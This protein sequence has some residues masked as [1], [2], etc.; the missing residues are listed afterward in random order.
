MKK[1]KKTSLVLVPKQKPKL[2]IEVLGGKAY[3]L[4]QMAAIKGIQVPPFFVVTADLYRQLL[5]PKKA[6]KIKSQIKSLKAASLPQIEK[7]ALNIRAFFKSSK[8]DD[9]TTQ[10]IL[11]AFKKLGNHTPVAVRSSATCEDLP[12]A[13]FAGQQDTYLNVRGEKELLQAVKNCL[14]SLF[15]VRAIVYRNEQKINHQKAALSVVVQK[16]INSHVSGVCFSVE[17]TT[18]FPEVIRIDA[19]YGLGEAIVQGLVTPDAFMVT[20]S[21]FILNKELGQKETQ[22]IYAKKG[23]KTLSVKPILSTKW[24]M[25]D[26]KVLKL[27]KKVKIL[28]N[29]YQHFVDVEFAI[30]T[31]GQIF[32]VQVR[33]ETKWQLLKNK[34]PHL[35][36]ISK[37]RIKSATKIKPFVIGL[38]VSPGAAVGDAVFIKKG[39][40]LSKVKPGNILMA[41]RTDPDLVPAMQISSGVVTA[42]G[43]RTSHAAIVSRELGIPAVVGTQDI[44]ALKKLSGQTVTIDGSKGMVYNQ[45]LELAK[46]AQNIDVKKL[47]ATKTRIGLILADVNQA[48]KLSKLAQND[49]EVGLLRAEFMLGQIAIHPQALYEFDTKELKRKSS[50]VY[51]QVKTTLTQRGYKNGYQYFVDTLASGLGSF[52]L[53]FKDRPVIYRTTD[54]KTNEYKDQLIGGDFY[55]P[56]EENPMIGDRGVG[57]YIRPYNLRFLG[58]EL[59]A[60]KKAQQQYQAKNIEVMLPFIRTL[61]EAK[62]ATDYVNSKIDR[63]KIKLI[64]MAEIPSNAFIAPEFITMFDGFSIGSNDMTQLTLGVDR[65]NE[66]LQP[67][68]DEHDPAAVLTFLATI[69]TGLKH[70]KKVGFCGQGVSDSIII[71]GLV[72]IAGISSASVVSDRYLQTKQLISKLEK[73]NIKLKNLGS[74]IQSQHKKRL[75]TINHTTPYQKEKAQIYAELNWQAIVTRALYL[76]GFKNFQQVQKLIDKKRK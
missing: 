75:K 61:A 9:Q 68:Y 53:A 64:A 4:F 44:M 73:Q 42:S 47:P 22:I 62:Q 32:I 71:A 48:F 37:A 26:E 40:P 38:G 52:S 58:W 20:K 55:E 45:K 21:G 36:P 43:G 23:V 41:R 63:S 28:E 2:D 6:N 54:F 8:F 10:E 11:T 56:D 27:A 51:K 72:S 35:I 50:Q 3:N 69:F 33:P 18:G 67:T 65:D 14:A 17:P 59:D 57:R 66:L 19:S 30:D 46:Q 39:E 60:I 15:T 31:K 16:M 25:T 29:Y 49:F 74:W 24:C 12:D 34:N 13:S 7:K 76:S 5:K 1:V 70:N